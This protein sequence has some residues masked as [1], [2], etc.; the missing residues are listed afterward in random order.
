MA[1]QTWTR[2]GF[3][4][5]V[6]LSDIAQRFDVSSTAVANWRSR[7]TDFPS[8]VAMLARGQNPVYLWS[9][10]QDWHSR[11]TRRRDKRAQRAVERARYA[12]ERAQGRLS[13]AE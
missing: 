9:E 3:P 4:D 11:M 2:D 12:L 7:E 1:K 13:S 10:V 5:L 8:P 6:A